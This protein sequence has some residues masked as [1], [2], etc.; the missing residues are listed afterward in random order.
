MN[1][2]PN[3]R[4]AAARICLG[5]LLLGTSV[6][7]APFE[8]HPVR[9]R[10]GHVRT[11]AWTDARGDTATIRLTFIDSTASDSALDWTVD[12]QKGGSTPARD[13]AVYRVFRF[14][15]HP[16][17]NLRK[18]DGYSYWLRPSPS[19]QLDLQINGPLWFSLPPY[20]DTLWDQEYERARAAFWYVPA[21]SVY[22]AD[23]MP[24]EEDMLLRDA[25]NACIPREWSFDCSRSP[26][27]RD[28]PDLGVVIWDA[29]YQQSWRLTSI[30]GTEYSFLARRQAPLAPRERWSYAYRSVHQQTYP[31]PPSSRTERTATLDLTLLETRSIPHGLE[32]SIER[33]WTDPEH[34]ARTDTALFQL[35]T[36][37]EECLGGSGSNDS[38]SGLSGSS[39]SWCTYLIENPLWPRD[40]TWSSSY[41]DG[42]Y[43]AGWTSSRSTGRRRTRSGIGLV[44]EVS[45]NWKETGRGSI[46]FHT[47]DS[48]SLTLLGHEV[49]GVSL[50]RYPAPETVRLDLLRE[51]LRRDEPIL[52][53]RIRLDG[54]RERARGAAA[55]PLLD[56]RGLAILAVDDGRNPLRIPVVRP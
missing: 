35:D 12:V 56:R 41:T 25:G 30:D 24:L 14:A 29:P 19:F 39:W 28:L 27:G 50:S 47:T 37:R 43:M 44:D 15:S 52:V 4:S 36:L 6:P 32:L 21:G 46:F 1:T 51:R 33:I 16:D 11:W 49:P 13:T 7:A 20:T 23:G 22:M 40:S 3:L 18:M 42:S 45:R 26:S 17:T 5:T 2:L 8:F 48:V 34:P 55:L 9:V 31:P 10:P 38:I 54:H 53:E